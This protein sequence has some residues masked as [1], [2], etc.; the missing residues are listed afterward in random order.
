MRKAICFIFDKNYIK[1][2]RLAIESAKKYNPDYET[3]LLTDIEKEQKLADIQVSVSDLEISTSNWLI[4][5][6]VAV[7]EFALK[8][9][10][11]DTAIFIDGDVY[12]YNSFVDLQKDT[13]NHSIVIIPH[14]TKPLPNDNHF[15]Q[16]RTIAIAGNYN[17]GVWSASKK[18]LA[19]IEWWRN[20][21][22]LFPVT[23]P[24]VG[25]VAEQGW[26]R[27]ANDFDDNVKVFKHPGYNV[28]YWNIKYRNVEYKDNQWLIDDK[29]LVNI[30]FS[31]LKKDMNPSQMS[32]FQNRFVLSNNDPV[33]KLYS[34]YHNL[35]WK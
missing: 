6:R 10:N 11:F 21:T 29:N 26:L 28:A 15:P 4:V 24:D 2:G 23:R 33:Y 14:I 3:V 20:E 18:G 34:D 30:H 13:E 1:Q 22:S 12:S 32:V 27:F 5:G 19:F 25:L 7:V 8:K 31:G 35:V 9:L 16:N 17:T